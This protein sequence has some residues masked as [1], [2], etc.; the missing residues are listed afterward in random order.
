PDGALGELE[1][2]ALP[3]APPEADQDGGAGNDGDHP[4]PERAD[5]AV[6]PTAHELEGR[7]HGRDGPAH[8][9]PPGG[10]APDKIAPE[11]NDEGRHP[12]I[13]NDEALQGTD[14]DAH[15]KA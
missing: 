8:G 1:A 11:G 2:L 3:P 5:R 13:G 12:Q 7:V 10:T 4:A 15:R 9:D 6:R 14:A